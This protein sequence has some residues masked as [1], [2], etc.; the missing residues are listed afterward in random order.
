MDDRFRHD[1]VQDRDR[2]GEAGGLD[3][4]ARER[5]NLSAVPLAQQVAE[6]LR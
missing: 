2:I 1:G 6:R 5:W 3:D 4:N